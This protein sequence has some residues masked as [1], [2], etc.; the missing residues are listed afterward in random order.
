MDAA[1][2][3]T[4]AAT[5]SLV[6]ICIKSSVIFCDR[7]FHTTHYLCA[8]VPRSFQVKFTAA[9]LGYWDGL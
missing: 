1:M 9:S 5:A 3:A 8:L 6:D 4:V 7:C 2:A